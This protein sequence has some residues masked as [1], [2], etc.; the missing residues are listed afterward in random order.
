LLQWRACMDY[1]LAYTQRRSYRNGVHIAGY[2]G[3]ALAVIEGVAGVRFSESEL[4]VSPTLP[5]EWRVLRLR[6]RHRGETVTL[7]ITPDQVVREAPTVLLG[8]HA[9]LGA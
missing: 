3:G 6:L 9:R 8:D 5:P 2:A 4:T 7:T 1:N